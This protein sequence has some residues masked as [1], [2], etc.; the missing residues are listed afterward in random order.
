MLQVF[1]VP[2]SHPSQPQGFWV[3]AQCATLP[4]QGLLNFLVFAH[5]SSAPTRERWARGHS[6]AMPSELPRVSFSPGRNNPTREA[7]A[8]RRATS[9]PRAFARS[10]SFT[11]ASQSSRAS[12]ASPRS[13]ASRLSFAPILARATS[14]SRSRASSCSLTAAHPRLPSLSH[15]ASVRLDGRDSRQDM[16]VSPA[17][18]GIREGSR[19]WTREWTREGTR[20]GTREWTRITRVTN[21][22]SGDLPPLSD[23]LA[24]GSAGSDTCEADRKS[25]V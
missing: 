10:V 15:P 11:S 6:W 25:V 19:E 5:H 24:H 9:F 18:G 21:V 17:C 1:E 4:A 3:V 20:E 13:S 7:R 12:D 22:E 8:V 2:F 23:I 16:S 14:L